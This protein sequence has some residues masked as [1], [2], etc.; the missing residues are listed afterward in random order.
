MK[1]IAAQL[2]RLTG[3]ADYALLSAGDCH[4]AVGQVQDHL[5]ALSPDER[6]HIARAV[7]SRRHAYSTG[8]YLAKRALREVGVAVSS[9]PTHPSRRPVWPDGVIGSITHS[10]RYAIAVVCLGTSLA[11]IGVDLELDRRVTDTIA[12]TTMTERE[13]ADC[14]PAAYT[15]NFSAKEA[16]FK[17]VNPIVGLM[18]GFKEVEIRWPPVEH[19]F[20]A[21]YVGPN[22]QNAI[23]D[24]GRGAGFTLDGHVGALFWMAA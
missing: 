8:R 7:P 23:L 15:A 19:A 10:R 24:A 17:A 6:R 5:A 22:P 3:V 18:V 9:I 1:D 12:A 4:A 11:G 13:L 16:V 21:N 2:G 14:P 20:R